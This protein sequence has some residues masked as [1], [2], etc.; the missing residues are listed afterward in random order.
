[1]AQ[2]KLTPHEYIQ[3]AFAPQVAILCSEDA[4]N[5]CLKNNLRFVELIQPF[6]RLNNEIRIA[7]PSGNTVPVRNLR[8]VFEDMN[9]R[10]PQPTLGKKLLSEVVSTTPWDRPVT[11]TVGASGTRDALELELQPTT[12][13]FEA[14]RDTFLHVQYPSDHEFT[15]HY[16]ACIVVVASTSENPMDQLNRLSQY[17]HQQL[18]QTPARFPK[19]FSPNILKFYLLIHD[20]TVGDLTKSEQVF[21]QMT[22]MYGSSNCHL[23]QINS[24]HTDQ[25]DV[26]LPDPWSQ[27][28]I[29]RA[30]CDP[31][32]GSSSEASSGTG[33]PREDV[34]GLPSRVTEG[35]TT[36]NCEPIHPLSPTVP[37]ID[38][39]NGTYD[40]MP[41]VEISPDVPV[42]VNRP[43]LP[44]G[45]VQHHGGC[46]TSSDVDR[47]RIFV[48]EFCVRSLIP[49]VER[50]VRY[51]ND[52]VTNRSRSKS[53]L[54][55][56]RR[57]LVGNKSPGS[58]TNSVIYS[59]EATELQTRRL[60]D[61][62]FM[63]G[64][65]ELSYSFYHTAKNDFKSDQAWLYFAGAQ[66]MAALAAFMQ[67]SSDYPKR[68]LENSLQTYLN[69][70]KV[71][72]FAIRSTL[73]SSEV[74]KHCGEYGE[75]AMMFIKL[76]SEESDLLS[77]L[78]L[79]QAAHCFIN[80]QRPLPR[81]Y[82]FHMTL[83]GHR[84]SKAGQRSHS[85]RA[86]KQAFQVYATRGWGLAEDHIH[87]TLGK[88]AHYLKQLT[89]SLEAYSHLVD[90]RLKQNASSQQSSSQQMTYVREF[91]NTFH[92]YVQQ[93]WDPSTGL[94]CLPLPLINSQATRVLLGA[95]QDSSRSLEWTPASHVSL[96]SDLTNNERWF[97][98]ER[99]LLET[100]Q[101]SSLVFRPNLQLLSSDTPNTQ[102]P[103]VPV[104]EPVLVE[105]LMENPLEVSLMISDIRL[106]FTFVPENNVDV[107]DAPVKDFL[108]SGFN[109]PAG[110]QEKVRLELHPQCIGKLLIKGVVYKL[111]LTPDMTSAPPPGSSSSPVIIEGQQ[112][113][114]VKGPRLNNTSAEKCS[115]VYA[116]DKRLEITVVPPMSRLNV[117]FHDIPQILSCGELCSTDVLITNVGPCPVSK[118]ML[119]V[120]DPNHVYLDTNETG[121][122]AKHI[123]V[124]S[125]FETA[126]SKITNWTAELTLPNG[127]LNSGDVL[128]AKLCL[129]APMTPG[130]FDVELLF[131]YETLNSPGRSKY[132]LVRHFSSI[133][134]ERSLSLQVS[135]TISQNLQESLEPQEGEN[136]ICSYTSNLIIEAHNNSEVDSSCSSFTVI[137]LSGNSE[138]WAVVPHANLQG[139]Q[140]KSGESSHLGV[141]CIQHHNTKGCV[142]ILSQLHFGSCQV[143]LNSWWRFS[144]RERISLLDLVT[145]PSPPNPTSEHIPPPPTPTQEEANRII[146]ANSLDMVVT[147]LWKGERGGRETWGQHSIH[148]KNLGDS[149]SIPS[150]PLGH[151]GEEE[152]P[153]IRIIPET[154]LQLLQSPLPAA[155]KQKHFVKISAQFPDCLDHDFI[156]NRL[157][158]L[159]FELCLHNCSA[160]H[161]TTFLNLCPEGFSG[162]GG[163]VSSHVYSPQASTQLLYVGGTVRK[164]SLLPWGCS[165]VPVRVLI[166]CPG[167]YSLGVFSVTA[168]RRNAAADKAEQP[169]PQACQLQTAVTVRQVSQGNHHL[170]HNT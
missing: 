99:N 169:I 83:A 78:M 47:I 94:P 27:F 88:Q 72:N 45:S 102:S 151:A 53:L 132:R 137:G 60:G 40:M 20:V 115:V 139:Q 52:V 1:M 42:M 31:S 75:A 134:V 130:A 97:S 30:S 112:F 57:W 128:N 156:A 103:V 25:T 135:S 84:F 36:D 110:A 90:Q 143:P 121:L 2:C 148:L 17:Q 64:L 56:T 12:P 150:L 32:G 6:C 50:Q 98:L 87:F 149:V 5:L 71:Y 105:V 155:S 142:L 70:C 35:D 152:K 51:L 96:D 168:L 4:D 164:V 124:L 10:P 140:L 48:H 85:L 104:N 106:V 29:Q 76:T 166:T 123:C 67:N 21:E 33:T 63:F 49:H 15:K 91:V 113:V 8:V 44:A 162:S 92:Q 120:S 125:D 41:G 19:W 93:E 157:C 100:S 144:L 159:E 165:V 80:S 145:D 129:H 22:S 59:P 77:A 69:V 79:E 38:E 141:K 147:V 118:L 109:L 54:S 65:Y 82:A 163:S 86:Y 61:L 62:C 81:K 13:W 111:C 58:A 127:L 138:K 73:L 39:K 119:A 108:Y 116:C 131:Y 66:E 170:I 114:E 95:P 23:L 46:L 153:P 14:W 11:R 3:N 89:E 133:Y 28:L 26:H 161:L 107:N 43:S 160:C 24:R 101:G 7:D 68:Y 117:S 122:P 158:S 136:R 9:R 74:L 16:I 34:S 146:A 167:T 126:D 18:H 154:P 55:A 37:P